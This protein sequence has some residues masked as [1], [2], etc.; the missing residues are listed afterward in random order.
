M[1]RPCVVVVGTHILRDVVAPG[2]VKDVAE[3]LLP[4]RN[5]E[6]REHAEQDEVEAERRELREAGQG[7]DGAHHE[8]RRPAVES[9]VKQLAER[10]ARARPARLLAVSAVC[11]A[12]DN[13]Q[14]TDD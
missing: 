13:A 8:H 1:L 12:H 2:Q 11:N 4:V 14:L 9:V 5:A 3:V 10:P 6:R 7:E